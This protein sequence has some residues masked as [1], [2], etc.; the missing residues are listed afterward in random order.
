MIWE[1]GKSFVRDLGVLEGTEGNLVDDV[2]TGGS[3]DGNTV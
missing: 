3:G 2:G 1:Q